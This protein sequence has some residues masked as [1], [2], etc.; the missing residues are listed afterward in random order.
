M[1]TSKIS[2][3]LYVSAWASFLLTF[4]PVA[5]MAADIQS[6]SQVKAMSNAIED[7]NFS[8]YQGGKVEVKVTTKKPLTA[9]PAGFSTNNPPRIALDF[10]DA[11]NATGKSVVDVSSAALRSINIVQSGARTRLVMNLT[12]SAGYETRIEGKTLYI[13]LQAGQ[14]RP[15]GSTNETTRFAE[16]GLVTPRAL[17]GKVDFRRG[18]NG[19][20]RIVV[21][22]VRCFNRD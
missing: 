19:E 7:V 13:T 14:P 11:A 1:I 22:L 21:G 17:V 15:P 3:K 18:S 6:G 12:K 5:G 9:P 10:P 16:A 4:G 8:T 2:K 20:G